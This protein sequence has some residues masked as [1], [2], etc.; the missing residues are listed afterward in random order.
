MKN[1]SMS[2]FLWVQFMVS[3]AMLG[4]LTPEVFAVS[5]TEMKDRWLL[6]FYLHKEVSESK[7]GELSEISGDAESFLE[8]MKFNPAQEGAEWSK[9]IE[10]EIFLDLDR[11]RFQ[12]DNVP[13]GECRFLFIWDFS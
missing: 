4:V 11:Q 2:E 6:K 3:Q 8:D 7:F 9:P 12:L 10:Y 5:L 13:G 1:V